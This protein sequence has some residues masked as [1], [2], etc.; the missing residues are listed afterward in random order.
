MSESYAL[1]SPTRPTFIARPRSQVVVLG[2]SFA[3]DCAANGYPDP[4]IVW[5]KDGATVDMQ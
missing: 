4:N 1:R 2:A 5:L 3:L